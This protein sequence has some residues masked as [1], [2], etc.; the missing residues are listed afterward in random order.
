MICNNVGDI[1][2]PLKQCLALAFCRDQN[3]DIKTLTETHIS[4]DQIYH[5]RNNWLGVILFSPGDCHT[6]GL[7]VLL[8]SDL[9]GITEVDIDPEGRFVSFIVTPSNDR[10]LCVYALQGIGIGNSWFH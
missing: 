2:D 4:H 9:E 6:K 1:R 3:R 5:I 7:L 8:H 10:V